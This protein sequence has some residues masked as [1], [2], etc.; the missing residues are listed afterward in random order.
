MECIHKSFS[1]FIRLRVSFHR[2]LKPGSLLCDAPALC[3]PSNMAPKLSPAASPSGSADEEESEGAYCGSEFDPDEEG[4]PSPEHYERESNTPPSSDEE[5]ME[6]ACGPEW[7]IRFAAKPA[8]TSS[9]TGA[10]GSGEAGSSTPPVAG[11]SRNLDARR[12][13]AVALAAQIAAEARGPTKTRW[14]KQ[15]GDSSSASGAAAVAPFYRD[16]G[17]PRK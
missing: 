4:I 12:K 15:G 17:D 5:A 6:Q 10:A 8:G 2:P 7:R 1:E 13:D 16:Q 11:P 9:A 14:S 3:A